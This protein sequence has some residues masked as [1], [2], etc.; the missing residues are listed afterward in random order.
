MAGRASLPQ[1]LEMRPLRFAYAGGLVAS[2]L[3]GYKLLSLRRGSLSSEEYQQRLRAYHTRSARQIYDGVM[4]LQGLMIKIGQ[5]IGSRPDT[6][7]EEYVRVLARLQDQVPPRS[8]ASMRPHIEQQLGRRFEDVFVEYD[9]KPVAAASLAQ[10]YKARLRDGRQVAV[11]VVYPNIERL[12]DTDLK[13]LRAVIWLET[14]LLYSFPLEPA[15]R[16]LAANIPL[17]VDMLHEARSMEAIAS[18]LSDRREIVIPGVVWECTS[19]RVLTMEYVDGIKVTDLD[20]GIREGLDIKK[21]SRMVVEVYVE[22]MLKHGH[23][24][25]DPHPG[26]LFALPGDRLAIVDFGLTKRLSP[27]FLRRSRR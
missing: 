13:L 25:A 5:T 6:F 27:E 9:P 11:K 21:L 22:L 20:R 18:L 3:T 7:P 19:E 8:W 24:H 14:R 1:L 10:V 15:F 16:E 4:R 12:V 23:F 2:I 17:E 26:N